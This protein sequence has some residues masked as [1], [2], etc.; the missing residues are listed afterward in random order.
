VN[1]FLPYLNAAEIKANEFVKWLVMITW[2]E[3]NLGASISLFENGLHDFIMASIPIPMPLQFPAIDNISYQIERLRL[4]Q[5]EKFEKTIRAAL[6]DAQ[7]NVGNPNSFETSGLSQIL[8]S[9]FLLAL[10]RELIG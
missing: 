3:Y 4:G 6:R 10:G 2:N 7:V 5:L 1:Q 9:V 8:L